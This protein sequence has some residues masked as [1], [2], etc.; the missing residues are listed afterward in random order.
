MACGIVRAADEGAELAQLQR[1]SS[2][3]AGRAGAR[4][5]AIADL[6]KQ[7]RSQI[8]VQGRD[9]FGEFQIFCFV[10]GF[11]ES[12]PEVAQQDLPIQLAVGHQVELLFQLSSKVIFDIAA[13]EIGQERCDQPAAIFGY[14]PTLL[15]FHVIAVLQNL[16]DRRVG[17]GAT[18]AE[19]FQL[20]HQARLGIA[21][22]RLSEM[23]VGRHRAALQRIAFGQWRQAGRFRILI[24]GYVVA[25]LLIDLEE[26]IED[27]NLPC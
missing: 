13:E 16:H 18:D 15:Q 14:E 10:D 22:R 17:R 11:G 8:L 21:R 27:L 7:M 20:F 12:F 2:L 25:I 3:A 23:L 1:Q 4:V 24:A 6:L 26:S 5:G 9:D 19:F